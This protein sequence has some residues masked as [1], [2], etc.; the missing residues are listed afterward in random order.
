MEQ[1]TVLCVVSLTLQWM[2]L[3]NGSIFA[4]INTAGYIFLTLLNIYLLYQSYNMNITQK[5]KNNDI[6]ISNNFDII[7][8]TSNITDS[9]GNTIPN[10]AIFIMMKMIQ[11]H[12]NYK[13]MQQHKPLTNI[14]LIALII[15]TYSHDYC[16]KMK[17]SRDDWY[18]NASNAVAKLHSVLHYK[19]EQQQPNILFHGT[20]NPSFDQF[21]K[22]ELFFKT[23]CSFTT[24]FSVA[25][26]FATGSMLVITH[27]DK[28]IRSGQL[29]GADVSWISP[30]H[31]YEWILLPTTFYSWR[32]MRQQEIIANGWKIEDH[33]K[34]YI[35]DDYESNINTIYHINNIDIA[36]KHWFHNEL[37]FRANDCIKYLDLFI[38]NGYNTF[39]LIQQITCQDLNNIGI[40]K[41]AHINYMLKKK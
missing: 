10:N 19:N 13:I 24:E 9:E 6:H 32:E 36:I 21:S 25:Q 31:E 26:K 12:S 29:K 14:E 3:Y 7:K 28:R 23:F 39:E 16:R 27:V 2:I 8:A 15:Y 4:S 5:H 35:T 30:Y 1:L 34:V 33:I 20:S 22:E 11:K 18:C 17:Q 41:I 37:G 40:I 38:N